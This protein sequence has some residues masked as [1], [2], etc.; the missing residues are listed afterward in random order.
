MCESEP[1]GL[2][3]NHHQI[4]VAGLFTMWI[5]IETR[6]RSWK[7]YKCSVHIACHTHDTSVGIYA[8]ISGITASKEKPHNPYLFSDQSI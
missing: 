7:L 1:P 8:R 5:D 2:Y 3:Y 6:A 4:G